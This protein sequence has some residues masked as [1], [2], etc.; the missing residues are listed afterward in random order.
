[1]VRRGQ[2][3]LARVWHFRSESGWQWCVGLACRFFIVSDL[4]E[5]RV[6]G[7]Y[8]A[9]PGDGVRDPDAG[10]LWPGPELQVLWPIVVPDAV[11]VMDGFLRQQVTAE[12][13]LH[14]ENMFEHVL[15]TLADSGVPGRPEHDVAGLVP[16]PSSPPVTIGCASHGPALGAGS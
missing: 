2:A 11:T 13:V 8:V 6:A 3:L 5:I 10:G 16:G 4:W 15:A 1:M 12:D 7:Q 14:D 9:S